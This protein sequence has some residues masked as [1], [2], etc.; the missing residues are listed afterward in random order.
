M[1][2][3]AQGSPRDENGKPT[4]QQIVCVVYNNTTLEILTTASTH[5]EAAELSNSY[6]CD[7][8][9]D[10]TSD[11]VRFMPD[12]IQPGE[13]IGMKMNQFESFIL[14]HPNHPLCK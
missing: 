6:Y 9:I 4:E 11:E 5:N 7:N 8:K 3:I 13:I 10:A 12:T 1:N 14:N 2:V